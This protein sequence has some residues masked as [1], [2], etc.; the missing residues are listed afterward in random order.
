MLPVTQTALSNMIALN[1]SQPTILVA[2]TAL[3]LLCGK[4]HVNAFVGGV[5]LA[6]WHKSSFDPTRLAMADGGDAG[7]DTPATVDPADDP[8]SSKNDVEGSTQ[9]REKTGNL[10]LDG[11]DQMVLYNAVPLFTGGIVLLFSLFLTGYMFYAGLT[12]DDPLMGHPK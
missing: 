12:G 10:F 11:E 6:K 9:N 7:K 3:Y 1:R 4:S 2:L 5:Q 8:S